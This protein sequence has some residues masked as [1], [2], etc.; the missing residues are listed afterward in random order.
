MTI[1]QEDL[2][3]LKSRVEEDLKRRWDP[4]QI[5]IPVKLS[6][7]K[8]MLDELEILRAEPIVMFEPGFVAVKEEELAALETRLEKLESLKLY[9]EC[10]LDRI[11]GG[12]SRLREAV[13]SLKE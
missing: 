13:K 6:L 8:E 1:N 4:T 10:V 7:L 5:S 12:F 9:A 2:A 11:P 3:E